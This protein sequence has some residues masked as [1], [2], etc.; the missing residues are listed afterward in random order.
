MKAKSLS[1]FRTKFRSSDEKTVLVKIGDVIEGDEEHLRAL[2]RNRLVELLEGGAAV[3]GA[4]DAGGP[5]PTQGDA[6]GE[7]KSEPNN[8]KGKK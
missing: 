4:A 6:G 7:A 1:V 3:K 8:G 5:A 2:A